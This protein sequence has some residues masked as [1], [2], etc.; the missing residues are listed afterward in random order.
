MVLLKYDE[1]ANTIYHFVGAASVNFVPFVFFKFKLFSVKISIHMITNFNEML[2]M[3]TNFKFQ[4]LLWTISTL[5]KNLSSSL[6][7]TTES[8]WHET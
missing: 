5:L 3:C 8:E 1:K 4:G 6:G 7:G 2:E